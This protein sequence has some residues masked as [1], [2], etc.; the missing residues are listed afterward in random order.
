MRG[1]WF[2]TAMDVTPGC[3][4]LAKYLYRS[5]WSVVVAKTPRQRAAVPPEGV[6][7]STTRGFAELHV[8]ASVVTLVTVHLFDQ[9]SQR[10][11]PLHTDDG[12]V[13]FRNTKN[14]RTQPHGGADDIGRD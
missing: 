2:L 8:L 1:C 14:R 7:E 6:A 3:L 4:P 5:A 11:L 10:D 9:R 13:M 12:E